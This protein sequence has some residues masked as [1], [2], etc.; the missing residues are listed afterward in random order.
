MG[1][2][3]F[4]GRQT[5]LYQMETI[6]QPETDSLGASRKVLIV[7]GMGGIGK[8]QLS[9]NYAKRHRSSYSSILWLNATSKVS[10]QISLR[11]VARRIFPPEIASHLKDEEVLIRISNWL[12]ELENSRWLLIFDNYDD[13]SQY[14]IA[15]YFP[16]V[17]HGSIIITTRQPDR[18]N[19]TRMKVRS[20]TEKE[21]SLRILA[22]RSGRENAIIGKANSREEELSVLRFQ[23]IPMLESWQSV[24]TVIRWRLPQPVLF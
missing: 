19:G 6:L 21:E 18:V 10:L 1:E 14:D 5:E 20:M 4:I 16:S 17:A 12:S 8:T 11:H 22:T 2:G 13:P 3:L 9:I 23:Q 24:L 7:G 15:Q